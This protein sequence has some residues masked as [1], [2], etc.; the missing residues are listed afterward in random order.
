MT[1]LPP[2]SL[3]GT[4]DRAALAPAVDLLA[5]LVARPEVG[6]HWDDESSCAGMS[7]GALA[8]HL[9]N[10][11]QRVVEVLGGPAP[12]VEPIS[13][14][15]HYARAAWL[16]QDLDGPA[17]VGVRERG[18]EQAEAGQA[19]AVAAAREARDALAA[20]L[21][22]AG[23]TVGLPWA[24]TA[25]RTDDF[26]VTRLMEIVVH[27]DDLAASVDVPVPA[28]A[29]EAL[30]PVLTLL[31]DLSLRRH[32]QDALVRALSRPQRAPGSISA[33]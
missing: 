13:L 9:V 17:N 14:D 22:A 7:V 3:A 28:F 2:L 6:E 31:T 4:L 5:D 20:T 10:Q 32:G 12:E 11:P 25:L 30:G 29:P 16:Q 8:W 27:S 33:F 24:G 15:E 19:A 1:T 18:A 26:L 21:A 23:P